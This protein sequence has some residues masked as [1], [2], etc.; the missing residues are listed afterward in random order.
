VQLILSPGMNTA[1]FDR[2]RQALRRVVGTQ[3]VLDTDED[4]ATYIDPY[5]VG[6]GRTHAPCGAVAPASVEELQAVLRVAN[7]FK[8]PLWPISRGK[9]LGYGGASPR[10]PGTMVLDLGRLNRILEVDEKLGYCVVEPGVGF[11]ELHEHLM[12]SRIA[13]EVGIPGNG[14]GSVVGNALERG[15]SFRGDHSESICGLEVVLPN[16]E[17]LRTG[18]G[19]M[20]GGANWAI[21]RHGF[22][23]SWDQT[24]V[25]S[26]FGVVTKMGLWLHPTPEEVVT[27]RVA[28]DAPDDI[29]WYMDALAPLRLRGVVSGNVQLTTYMMTVIDSTQRADWY[30]G[31]DSLPDSIIA[32][33]RAE[34]G[35][36]WWNGQV[37][38]A[39]YADV[40]NGNLKRVQAALLKYS[41]KE[42]PFSRVLSAQTPA[43]GPSVNPLKVANWYGGR[44]G[45]MSFSPVVPA[46]GNKVVEQFRRTRARYIEHGID[47]SSTW[48]LNGRTVTNIN[49][50]L[51][52]MD[53][54]ELTARGNR[55]FHALV[56]DGAEQGYGEYRTH[57]TYMDEVADT[58]SYNDHA[59]RRFNERVK[60]AID[61]NGIL[62]PG[63]NGIWPAAWRNQRGKI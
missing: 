59:L 29:G 16:G 62:A 60:D 22:G 8:L 21:A 55:L 23:P 15:F 48:Y 40:N 49:L 61:P 27:V 25:Q 38:I 24:F 50:L 17:L 18:N 30:S 63:R 10:M 11:F 32:R 46:V 3:W 58:F 2:A 39:G 51:T 56:K 47:Y 45:H 7:D 4:R 9:N 34:R 42:Y 44:G 41:G 12:Q 13:M 54:A 57:L 1:T 20:K 33:I 14:W 31:R 35:L 37:R 26:N 52:N 36:G 53:D 28:L 19:A 43:R 6:D 5:A